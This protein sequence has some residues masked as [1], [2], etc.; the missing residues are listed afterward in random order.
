MT[1]F[2]SLERSLMDIIHEF[3]IKLGLSKET[4]RLFYPEK[5]LCRLMDC[6][7]ELLDEKLAEFSAVTKIGTV[8]F[9]REDEGRLC[10]V[11]SPDVSEY[12]HEN[13]SDGGFLKELITAAMFCPGGMDDILKVFNRYG[14]NV[15]CEYINNG[16]F[17][18]LVYF[19]TGIPDGYRYCFKLHSDHA[20]YHRFTKED[21]E[22]FGF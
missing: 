5:T 12:T 13:Y 22:D 11:V 20:A 2:S 3:E 7:P 17:D 10:A 6:P 1:D 16:E 8:K 14:E 4:L 21:Y 18:Y 9:V 15:K 19:E